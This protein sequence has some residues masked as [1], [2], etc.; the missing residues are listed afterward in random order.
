MK[1][2]K[3]MYVRLENG[4]I[5]KTETVNKF[6]YGCPY[7]FNLSG[8][9]LKVKDISNTSHNLIDL[10][11]VGDYVNGQQVVKIVEAHKHYPKI[12]CLEHAFNDE[13]NC[14]NITNTRDIK[15]IL[16]KEQYEAN[17]FRV[18]EEQ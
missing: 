15:E 9:N 17:V 10:I 6:E 16:T 14:L 2:E 7:D 4:L 18:E 1:I 3:G 13:G 8:Y 5:F 11:E 12:I